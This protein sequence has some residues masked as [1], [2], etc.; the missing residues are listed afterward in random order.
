MGRSVVFHISIS[1]RR[2]LRHGWGDTG[3]AQG[4]ARALQAQGAETHLFY[5]DEDPVVTGHNDVVLRIVGP[6]LAEPVTGL[7]NLVWIISPPNF[8]SLDLLRRYQGVF[9]ASECLAHRLQSQQVR[10][11]VMQQATDP[12]HFNP[13]LWPQDGG[14]LPIAFVGALDKR[15]PRPQVIAAVRA[16]LPVS[17]WGPG[18]EGAIPA[19]YWRGPHLDYD[20]LAQVY[21]RAQIILNS[22]M[23]RMAELGMMSNRSFDALA[24]GAAVVSDRVRG[25]GDPDLPDLHQVDS[26]DQMIAR[27]RDLLSQPAPGPDERRAR[28][29]RVC[30]RYNFAA[31]AADLIAHARQ[32]LDQGQVARPAFGA[33]RP[34]ITASVSVPIDDVQAMQTSAVQ[35][36]RAADDLAA[37]RRVSVPPPSDADVIHALTADLRQ[38]VQL[39]PG[40]D[41]ATGAEPL[42]QRARL[43]VEA[44]TDR[45]SPFALPQIA[46]QQAR[47]LNFVMMQRPLWDHQ[48]SLFS[49]DAQKVSLR[50]QPRARSVTMARPVGVFLHLYY[51]DLAPVFADRLSVIDA[52]VRVYISTDGDD[53]AALIRASFPDAD[54]R[55]TENRGRDIYPKLFAF[56]DAYDAHDVVLHL[57]GKK[58]LHSGRLDQ[59]L[60]HILDCLLPSRDQTN[61][62]LSLFQTIPRLGLVIPLTFRGVLK[63]A[64]WGAN[65]DIGRELAFRMGLTDPLPDDNML[66]FPVGSMFWGRVSALRPVLDLNL[67]PAHFPPESGQVDGT[68]AH[69][70][71]RMIG[72]GCTGSGHHILPVA[73]RGVKAHNRFLRSYGRN[74]DLRKAL[75]TGAFYDDAQD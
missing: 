42:L 75:D 11:H 48:P 60:E 24:S 25:F 7:P 19:E 26:C 73:G 3:Y 49:R 4:L 52:P 64:H 14:P 8:A 16:G 41:A 58:S 22:H 35:I 62:I 57:H 32:V 59:W 28:H 30:T 5:R 6:H 54:I 23:P 67:T 72:V 70:I 56:S 33:P 45:Q 43:L 44:A 53:K 63:A 17:V 29:D 74:A 34:E 27:L 1:G 47:I 55:V 61:R 65:Y 21:A 69:A 46:G 10:A 9:C 51:A 38:I 50:L 36:V 40:P 71:E 37:G 68:L 12:A 31:R 39:A 2:A 18:W 20:G 15:A 66:R 13:D